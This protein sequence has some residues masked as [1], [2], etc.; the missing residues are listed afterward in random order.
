AHADT[1]GALAY[2]AAHAA[3]GDQLAPTAWSMP[4]LEFYRS[5]FALA[6]LVDAPAIPP[7]M[8][9]AAYVNGLRA[10]RKLARTWVLIGHRF[11]ERARF[12]AAARALAP[13][14]DAWEGEG[15][16]TYLFDF[17]VLRR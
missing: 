15:A 13:E 16:G 17:G 5:R 9:A 4:A 6:G 11:D 14:L 7:A 8:D 10:E 1:K 12:L 2:V 3:P